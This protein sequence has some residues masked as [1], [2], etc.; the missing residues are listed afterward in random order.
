TDLHMTALSVIALV[1]LGRDVQLM[2][3]VYGNDSNIHYDGQGARR[4]MEGARRSLAARLGCD[5]REIVF[6]SGG[7]EADNLAIFAVVRRFPKG[8]HVITSCIEHPAVLN[9]CAQLDRVGY[10]V[11]SLP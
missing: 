3:E 5:P 2:A 6:T 7:T 1:L 8:S 9:A 4:E 10:P 11:T